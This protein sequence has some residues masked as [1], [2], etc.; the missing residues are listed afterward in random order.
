MILNFPGP[1]QEYTWGRL[2][3]RSDA[4]G[5]THVCIDMKIVAIPDHGSQTYYLPNET[6]D[7]GPQRRVDIFGKNGAGDSIV[8]YLVPDKDA[9]GRWGMREVTVTLNGGVEGKKGFS[10]RE[11]EF[12]LNPYYRLMPLWCLLAL[13]VAVAVL[14]LLGY[15]LSGSNIRD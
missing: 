4:Q 12:F 2:Y 6:A 15:A 8:T 5:R 1:D 3:V 11:P 9:Q 13:C 10:I 14:W 7:T